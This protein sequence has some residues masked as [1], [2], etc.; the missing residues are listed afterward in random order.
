MN[1]RDFRPYLTD[2]PQKA[3]TIVGLTLI[4]LSGFGFFAIRPTITTAIR[5]NKE[6]REGLEANQALEDKIAALSKAQESLNQAEPYLP[7]LEAGLP[8]EALYD[9]LLKLVALAT[10]QAQVELKEVKTLG[11]SPSK[12]PLKSLRLNI[13]LEGQFPNLQ[14]VIQSLEQLPRLSVVQAVSLQPQGSWGGSITGPTNQP[15]LQAELNLECYYYEYQEPQVLL[16]EE[17]E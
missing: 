3:Y 4:A 6:R 9:E 7:L 10:G 12:T 14:K 17:D 5:L 13:I 2:T 8:K 16:K 11:S 15:K 1:Y